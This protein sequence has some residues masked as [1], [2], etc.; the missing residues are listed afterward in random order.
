MHYTKTPEGITA[1]QTRDRILSTKQRQLLILIGGHEFE[2][3][4]D[5]LKA[6][7]C[8]SDVIDSLLSLGFIQKEQSSHQNKIQTQAEEVIHR[9]AVADVIDEVFDAEPQKNIVKE[10]L[11]SSTVAPETTTEPFTPPLDDIDY[12]LDHMKS[13]MA[14][15]LNKYCGLMARAHAQNISSCNSVSAFK[16]SHMISI[17]LLQESN[18]P[19]SELTHLT[20]TLHQFYSKN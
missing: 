12:S 17:T 4:S 16:R 10:T 3:L 18:M 2:K 14:A 13:L 19:K 9:V 11:L 8:T 6:K 5:I 7:L 20:Q 1:L 15:A